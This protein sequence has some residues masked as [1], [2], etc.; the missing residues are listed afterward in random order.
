MLSNHTTIYERVYFNADGQPTRW[1]RRLP[2]EEWED[3]EHGFS[4]IPFVLLRTVPL[5]IWIE[6]EIWEEKK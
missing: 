3:V 5:P 2:G 4:F 1:Q 6:R